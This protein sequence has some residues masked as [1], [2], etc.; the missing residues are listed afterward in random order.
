ML[1]PSTPPA[2][3]PHVPSLFD[4]SILT[5]SSPSLGKFHGTPP[6]YYDVLNHPLTVFINFAERTKF[7]AGEIATDT[8][9]EPNEFGITE[10]GEEKLWLPIKF[11]D[12]LE[13][14][15]QC[16]PLF[17]KEYMNA[18]R[19]SRQLYYRT[20]DKTVYASDAIEAYPNRD[21]V[22][23]TPL[24]LHYV[25][26]SIADKMCHE[27]VMLVKI[28][29][30]IGVYSTF[31][32]LI[33]AY[34]LAVPSHRIAIFLEELVK[35]GIFKR[36]FPGTRAYSEI[37]RQGRTFA[38]NQHSAYPETIEELLFGSEE[39]NAPKRRLTVRRQSSA[40]LAGAD[41]A[42]GETDNVRAQFIRVP[43]YPHECLYS[44][45]HGF[46]RDV[47]RGRMLA[48]SQIGW[49]TTEI[50]KHSANDRPSLD[51]SLLN[52]YGPALLAD[53]FQVYDRPQHVKKL[54]TSPLSSPSSAYLDDLPKEG[55]PDE[56]VRDVDAE[57]DAVPRYIALHNNV[58]TLW[59]NKTHFTQF[60][61]Q[62]GH[63][64]RGEAYPV[65][66]RELHHDDVTASTL[67]ESKA[68][69]LSPLS[70]IYLK[71]AHIVEEETKG[72]RLAIEAGTYLHRGDLHSHAKRFYLLCPSSPSL[73]ASWKTTF[74]NAKTRT[75]TE[76]QAQAQKRLHRAQVE[77]L[78]RKS[79]DN[80]PSLS[81][82]ERSAAL[83]TFVKQIRPAYVENYLSTR[84]FVR[85]S[86]PSFLGSKWKLRY[87]TLHPNALLIDEKDH[88][89]GTAWE[90]TQ[91]CSLE[92]GNSVRIRKGP[93]AL[94]D[95][96]P[97]VIEIQ[98]DLHYRR[99]KAIWET[100]NVAL[101][102]DEVREYE[103]W[104]ARLNDVVKN[105]L[106]KK[107]EDNFGAMWRHD[108]RQ[109]L[110]DEGKSAGGVVN[111][112][113]QSKAFEGTSPTAAVASTGTRTRSLL[114]KIDD[115]RA[116]ASKRAE[117]F[118]AG[119]RT[120]AAEDDLYSSA[121]FRESS[122][123]GNGNS[124]GL[125]L[126]DAI[127]KQ[128]LRRSAATSFVSSVSA[129]QSTGLRSLR[130]PT[131]PDEQRHIKDSPHS[132]TSTG[133]T[134]VTLNTRGLDPSLRRSIIERKKLVI[135]AGDDGD[136]ETN[137]GSLYG[138]G[139][140][141]QGGTIP[142]SESPRKS[143]TSRRL[144]PLDDSREGRDS[145]TYDDEDD[146]LA[147][148]WR[149]DEVDVLVNAS[150]P[151]VLRQRPAYPTTLPQHNLPDPSPSS[152]PASEQSLRRVGVTQGDSTETTTEGSMKHDDLEGG[153]SP[154]EDHERAHVDA[155]GE[156]DV[157]AD[158]VYCGEFDA[159]QR[160][161]VSA[162][163]AKGLAK[164]DKD[165][166]YTLKRI[167]RTMDRICTHAL[168]GQS[169]SV[170]HGSKQGENTQP[171]EGTLIE[172]LQDMKGQVSKLKA[173][174][175]DHLG[176]LKQA[177][178]DGWTVRDEFASGAL[179]VSAAMV[180][181]EHH[182]ILNL[183]DVI[184]RLDLDDSNKEWLKQCYTA[185]GAALASRRSPQTASRRFSYQSS[186][187]DS[188]DSRDVNDSRDEHVLESKGET[189]NG[190]PSDTSTL[191]SSNSSR[192][193]SHRS[194]SS[195]NS[196]GHESTGSS[197][198]GSSPL[199]DS[200][201]TQERKER[202]G[203]LVSFIDEL[204][205]LK[206]L[207]VPPSSP[208]Q[209]YTRSSGTLPGLPESPNL[210]T[211]QR[212]SI[213]VSAATP[214]LTSSS[215]TTMET[216]TPR[217]LVT[218]KTVP[219]LPPLSSNAFISATPASSSTSLVPSSLVSRGTCNS[220]DS[221]DG[222]TFYLSVSAGVEK[223]GWNSLGASPDDLLRAVVRMLSAFD[224]IRLFKIP[225]D[226]FANFLLDV[227]ASYRLNPYHNFTHAVDVMQSLFAILSSFKASV[228]CAIYIIKLSPSLIISCSYC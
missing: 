206:V 143:D 27:Q 168:K 100:R 118:V 124:F 54:G 84:I 37:Y 161:L 131:P 69:A 53:D 116:N 22:V 152:T 38:P 28:S 177:R 40:T 57:D 186:L 68:V 78:I 2:F 220:S 21:V 96:R 8:F 190:L 163:K 170:S 166:V 218:S 5:L 44:L 172:S 46:M 62:K 29:T 73:L 74:E 195:S 45:R 127:Q 135:D 146:D 145:M 95:G 219:D 30:V 19:V 202:V 36:I 18:L 117:Q 212:G 34:P 82:P 189:I 89:P 112:K 48:E 198:E 178:N 184:N 225:S 181:E 121:I 162:V 119:E 114:N 210:E 75:Y 7:T 6:A 10:T 216:P 87:I 31:S 157:Y 228:V 76:A 71:T 204:D 94:Y 133:S 111:S 226:K 9:Y 224:F 214:L 130:D 25:L 72:H 125:A 66:S 77:Q 188:T 47:I 209:T 79:I 175:K 199:D 154:E 134:G 136:D 4:L 123:L 221:C 102:F 107:V 14:T 205:Q 185:E 211:E 90:P 41:T 65:I 23:P 141:I 179:T 173:C 207:D 26:G 192:S 201:L 32:M 137:H 109:P 223:W 213:K 91:A 35:R 160:L 81:E 61:S 67:D 208:G 150:A 138:D 50:K 51:P 63:K 176:N 99:G 20:K 115:A 147:E 169:S 191:S 106:L 12:L 113:G 128:D 149:F 158:E 103:V 105:H 187:G 104:T 222:E 196:S 101:S 83:T 108:G 132:R 174:L 122:A 97:Y 59:E 88:P 49:L 140:D 171:N 92:F 194:H 42:L 156:E 55:G 227:E 60:L 16:N 144:H 151:G 120:S 52:P 86:N 183:A 58:I 110:V 70:V 15:T 148:C 3:S 217:E 17:V 182:G 13:A 203:M 159:I 155:T 64:E 200:T 56:P 33:S 98:A 11:P 1:Y 85:K 39:S 215:A 153:G 43:R 180:P 142:L 139:D 165:L 164:A 93:V 193:D 80:P 24:S 197:I 129:S 167:A 126:D